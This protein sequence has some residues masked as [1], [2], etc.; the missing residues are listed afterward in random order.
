MLPG[1][2]SLARSGGG[3]PVLALPSILA[4]ELFSVVMS[5]RNEGGLVTT[6][7]SVMILSAAQGRG[8]AADL[9]RCAREARGRARDEALRQCATTAA[10]SRRGARNRARA[11]DGQISTAGT[12]GRGRRLAAPF[13]APVADSFT[14][15][16]Q[17]PNELAAVSFSRVICRPS[18]RPA[19]LAEPKADFRG[20]L[21]SVPLF[22][23]PFGQVLQRTILIQITLPTLT[24]LD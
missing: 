19:R 3:G 6:A 13:A 12:G 4:S 7:L 24:K 16:R 1:G 23:Q 5:R 2:I 9:R 8:P 20:K 18:M 10:A 22:R 15:G 14:A 11:R 17:A 21:E